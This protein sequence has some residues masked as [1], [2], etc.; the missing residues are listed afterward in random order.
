[1]NRIGQTAPALIFNWPA[2]VRAARRSHVWIAACQ[3]D[4]LSDIRELVLI[5]VCTACQFRAA[6]MMLLATLS[7]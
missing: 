5:Q 6:K 4:F 2:P 7:R 3:P 1:M